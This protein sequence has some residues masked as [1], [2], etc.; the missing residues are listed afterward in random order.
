MSDFLQRWTTWIGFAVAL[1]IA[2]VAPFLGDEVES[3]YGAPEVVYL[4]IQEVAIIGG[5][6]FRAGIEGRGWW[7]PNVVRWL[8]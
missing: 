2:F 7:D 3:S 1:Q 8:V 4:L 5:C 6:M